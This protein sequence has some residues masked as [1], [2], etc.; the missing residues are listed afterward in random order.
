MMKRRFLDVEPEEYE[1]WN[2]KASEWNPENVFDLCLKT[3]CFQVKDIAKS[4][5]QGE[6]SGEL[7]N[8]IYTYI[9]ENCFYMLVQVI[10]NG[11]MLMNLS[12]RREFK[13][14]DFKN[15]LVRTYK[16]DNLPSSVTVNDM[17]KFAVHNFP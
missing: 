3:D 13:I 1:N 12:N 8:E 15:G 17:C 6:L 7:S 9:S 14:Q 10:K 11:L 2:Y 4:I 16:F 5:L